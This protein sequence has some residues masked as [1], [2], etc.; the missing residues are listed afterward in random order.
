LLEHDVSADS[1]LLVETVGWR[2][3]AMDGSKV[4]V[5]QVDVASSDLD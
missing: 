3:M 2:R 5:Q 1:G 4:I